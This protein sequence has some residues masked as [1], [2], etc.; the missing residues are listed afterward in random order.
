MSGEAAA[1]DVSGRMSVFATIFAEEVGIE[2]ATMIPDAHALLELV[3]ER[4]PRS[5]ASPA[6]DAPVFEA[7]AFIGEWLRS[8]C[9]SVWVIEGGTEPHLQLIDDS[10]AIVVLLPLVALVRTAATAGYD[11]IA[12]LFDALV[13]DVQRPAV[14]GE[15]EALRVVPPEETPRVL[16]WVQRNSP[17]LEGAR[18]SLWRRCSACAQPQEESITLPVAGD[19]WEDDA[20]LAAT[21]LA[22]RPFRCPCGGPAGATTRF[23][24]VT[25]EHGSPRLCDLYATPTH[26]RVASWLLPSP[27]HIVPFDTTTFSTGEA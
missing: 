15:L 24:M 10:H 5:G 13:A 23:L 19:S 1:I 14:E 12:T 16:A 2:D 6:A 22:K 4:V 7:A 3:N 27:T 21:V 18:A 8:R 26:S 25:A 9:S 17:L 11:G 20:A